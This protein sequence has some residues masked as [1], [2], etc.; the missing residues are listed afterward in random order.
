M[1]L[2]LEIRFHDGTVVPAERV[3]ADPLHDFA[4]LRF[5]RKKAPP[6]VTSLPLVLRAAQVG[7]EVR[8]IGNNGGLAATL[9]GGTISNVDAFWDQDPGVNYLQTSIASAGGSSGSPV[10]DTRGHAI[11]MQAAHDEH[12]SYALPSE[13]LWQ[14]LKH[15]SVGT[16]PPRGTIG[17]R[18]R[19]TDVPEAIAS[20]ALGA[21]LAR[22]LHWTVAAADANDPPRSRSSRGWSPT[23]RAM[24]ERIPEKWC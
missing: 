15:L 17:L 5:D 23:R 3:F 9:L 21:D 19:R 1:V 2:D 12:T 13:Y 11:G 6:D 8:M 24:G 4:F 20:G 10:V 22:Q 7:E 16:P 14:A 18:V